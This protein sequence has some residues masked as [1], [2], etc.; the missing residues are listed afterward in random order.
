MNAHIV[1][2]LF[3]LYVAATSLYMV[4]SGRQYMVLS[5]LR[6]FWGR[7]RGYSL[8]FVANVALPLLI[9]VLFLG[10]GVR[11]YNAGTTFSG[12]TRPLHLNIESYRELRLMLQKERTSDPLGVLYGA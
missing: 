10:W 6:S 3:A 9:C 2:G 12:F 1:F 11:H 7:T 5:L 4:L 8:Y